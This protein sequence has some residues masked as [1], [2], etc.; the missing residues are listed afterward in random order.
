MRTGDE[1]VVARRQ[2]IDRERA[3]IVAGL[4]ASDHARAAPA[5]E[6]AGSRGRVGDELEAVR[7]GGDGALRKQHVRIAPA[8]D[9]VR[10]AV[11][12]EGPEFVGRESRHRADD[13]GEARERVARVRDQCKVAGLTHLVDDAEWTER[14]W[15]EGV[16]TGDERVVARRQANDRERAVIVAGLRA[17]DHARAAQH[18]HRGRRQGRR[19]EAGIGKRIEEHQAGEPAGRHRGRR[20]DPGR[21]E[22]AA[23]LVLTTTRGRAQR[24]QQRHER[25]PS[26]CVRRGN[27]GHGGLRPHRTSSWELKPPNPSSVRFGLFG[28]AFQFTR[29]MTYLYW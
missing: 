11:G 14:A 24:D 10:I 25:E 19:A 21:H 12:R 8:A 27:G 29:S 3:V 22:Q 13:V 23:R 18:L 7:T 2:A 5:D 26:A 4:R 20:P 6:P 28:S 17:S 9:R 1:R 15:R 16:R